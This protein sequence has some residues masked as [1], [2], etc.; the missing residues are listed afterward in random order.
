MVR[1]RGWRVE[2]L[3]FSVVLPIPC[4]MRHAGN[5]GAIRLPKLAECRESLHLIQ[6]Y[7]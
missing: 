3:W 6:S 5:M 4:R 7:Q 1:L 2:M